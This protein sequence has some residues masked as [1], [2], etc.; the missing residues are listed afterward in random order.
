IIKILSENAHAT[1]TE[2]GATVG[3]SVPA[4]NK[5]IVKLKE[6]GMIKQATVLTDAKAMNKA[7]MAY[8]LLAIQYGESVDNLLR[9]IEKDADVLE[10]YAVTGEYDYIVKVCASSVET[11]ENKLLFLKKQ[12]GVTKSQTMLSL[13]EHKFAPTVLPDVEEE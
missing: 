11:L 7:V 1:S 12:K 8:I 5:R 13:V 6:S 3:L 9:C 4:V 10:C 2:I